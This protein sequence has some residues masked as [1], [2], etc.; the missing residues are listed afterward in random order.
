M[1]SGSQGGFTYVA[2]LVAVAALGWGIAALGESWARIAQREKERELL[3]VGNQFRHAIGLYY[4]RSP[5]G[6]KRYPER[7]EDLLADARTLTPQRYLRRIYLDPVTGKRE[8]GVV[9]AP[10]GGITGVYSLSGAST[11]K[12]GGFGKADEKFAAGATYGDWRFVFEPPQ[13]PTPPK[14]SVV[15]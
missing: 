8:W 13:T 14:P 15:R 6:A 7:L 11:L 1:R 12:R 3:W 5:G 9:R 4:H 10:E 2:I